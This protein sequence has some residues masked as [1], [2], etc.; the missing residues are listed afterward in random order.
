MNQI[1]VPSSTASPQLIEA[2]SDDEVVLLY[3]SQIDDRGNLRYS[4]RTLESYR[5]DIKRFRVFLDGKTLNA[6]SLND[7]YQFIEWLKNPR[8]CN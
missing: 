3:L 7:I 1:V 2:D 8:D 4:E 6:V 5:R